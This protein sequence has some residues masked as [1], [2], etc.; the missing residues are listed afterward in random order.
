MYSPD[1]GALYFITH[2]S[3]LLGTI[4]FNLSQTITVKNH[5]VNHILQLIQLLHHGNY[6]VTVGNRT[7]RTRIKITLTIHAC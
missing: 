4:E 5:H 6:T 3:V 1:G 7:T 2:S